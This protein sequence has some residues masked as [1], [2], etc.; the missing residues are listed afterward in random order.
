MC[1]S[2][3][4]LVCLPF[5]KA[6]VARAI[7]EMCLHT[8]QAGTAIKMCRIAKSIDNQF[9]WFQTPLR[10]FESDIGINT[11]KAIESR[12][13]GN[14]NTKY[15]VLDTTLSLLDMTAAEVGQIC[16]SKKG[17]GQKIQRLVGLLP[18]PILSCKVLPVTR[19]VLRF[20][21]EI[22]PEFTWSNKFHG[23]AI[24]FW[25]WVEGRESQRM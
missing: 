25:F 8:N 21:V 2:F 24:S 1:L 14:S 17:V 20:Q 7:F 6:R 15:D 5:F 10:H 23:G 16:R 11:I 22:I 12:H 13:N 19:D 18:R 9:W 3:Q 4:H